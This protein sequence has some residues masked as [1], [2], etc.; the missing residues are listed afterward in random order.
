[1]LWRRHHPQTQALGEA[2]GRQK[3]HETGWPGLDPAGSGPGRLR[4]G[5]VT[6]SRRPEIRR[7]GQRTKGKIDRSRRT[8]VK[9]DGRTERQE[10]FSENRLRGLPET[11]GER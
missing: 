7:L 1:M 11:D 3:N 8:E 6:V 5:P 4:D 9:R 2:G 10:P